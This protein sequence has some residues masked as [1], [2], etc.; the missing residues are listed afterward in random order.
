MLP[1]H[2]CVG[3]GEVVGAPVRGGW[4]HFIWE[5]LVASVD[6]GW[7]WRLREGLVGG[8]VVRKA[9][10]LLLFSSDIGP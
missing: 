2:M 4:W 9:P 1:P 6:R 10:V 8:D 7:W 3:G 5:G